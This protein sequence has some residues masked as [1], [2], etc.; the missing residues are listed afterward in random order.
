MPTRC[1]RASYF[2]A[3]GVQVNATPLLAPTGIDPKSS[4]ASFRISLPLAKLPRGVTPCRPSRSQP[5][6]SSPRSDALIWPSSK[7][8]PPPLLQHRAVLRPEANIAISHEKLFLREIDV[9]WR[10]DEKAVRKICGRSE[11]AIHCGR[12]FRGLHFL[13]LIV[14]LIVL[15][16][17]LVFLVFLRAGEEL[18][19]PLL[20]LRRRSACSDS[21]ADGRRT[22]RPALS[23]VARISSSAAASG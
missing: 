1:A 8:R 3:D 23:V 12:D 16:V 20:L 22:C 4:T 2:S 14:L 17:F 13:V 18:P 9:G 15:L 11:S 7:R 21:E 19:A 10:A 6:R 5:G